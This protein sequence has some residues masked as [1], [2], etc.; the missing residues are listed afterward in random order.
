MKIE[1]LNRDDILALPKID[2]HVHLDG[3]L[4]PSTILDLAQQD[5]IPLPAHD[6][7]GLR[8][9]MHIGE[10]VGSLE[11]YLEAFEVTLS[12]LQGDGKLRRAAFELTEDA[13]AENVRYM[14]VRFSP[15]LHTREGLPLEAVVEAVRDGLRE[16]ERKFGVK[17]G[18]IICGIRNMS[19]ELSF[20]LAQLAVSFKADGVVGFDLAGSEY[21]N[22]PKEH[23]KS[24]YLVVSNNINCTVHAGEASGAESV[25]QAIHYLKANR[26]GHGTRLYENGDLMNYVNDH[27]IP[28]EICLKSN[29]QTGAVPSMEAHPFPMYFRKGIRVTINT[30]NRLITDTT[31][32]DELLL[33]NHA[34][35]LSLFD[36]KSLIMNGFKSMFQPYIVRKQYL[37]EMREA[38]GLIQYYT[39][40]FGMTIDH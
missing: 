22:P 24:F 3:S 34:F 17:S 21:N 28:L 7:A 13:A 4:R 10:P 14:E 25:H 2:L 11:K 16:G 31:V 26:I 39:P 37:R 5:N 19:P 36:I 12:V 40:D 29:V 1:K 20:K 6:E 33:A 8:Q 23:R 18:I 15:I 32:T 30:D 9:A 38:L 35:G 27:R